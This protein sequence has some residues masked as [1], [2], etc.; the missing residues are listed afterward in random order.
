MSYQFALGKI[1]VLEKRLPNKVDIDRMI[2]A[3]G[4]QK[5]FQVLNDTDMSDNLLNKSPQD[6]E[7]VIYD[8]IIQMRN[9]I[10]EISPDENLFN[11]LFLKY[12]FHNIKVLLKSKIMDR[13]DYQENLISTG[14]FNSKDLEDFIINENFKSVPEGIFKESLK[15]IIKINLLEKVDLNCDKEYFKLI[16]NYSKS[17]KSLFI[18]N[19]LKIEIDFTN[20]RIALRTDKNA[21]LFYIPKGNLTKNQFLAINNN[22]EE[23]VKYLKNFLTKSQE[24]FFN[25]F[26]NERKLWQLEKGFDDFLIDLMKNSRRSF[27]G[28][29]LILSYVVAK[30]IAFRNI[31]L[32]MTAKLN[33]IEPN[34]L[35]ERI[36]NVF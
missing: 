29:E 3:E 22:K 24:K 12:D 6:F 17:L 1:K 30:E 36:R 8:D 21:I 32:I 35:K 13:K 2:N 14:I 26:F 9:F 23:I 25:N 7:S 19:F 4:P 31:R 5:S 15:R 20:L 33:G 34:I 16:I 28:P 18:E 11:L 27:F 10:K